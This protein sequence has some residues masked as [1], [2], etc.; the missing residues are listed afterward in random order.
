MD[1]AW[2]SKLTA[3]VDADNKKLTLKAESKFIKDWVQ[4]NY[5]HLIDK[6]C[7]LHSYSLGEVVVV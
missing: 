7:S 3:N 5:S 1:N 4:S 6:L 2:F